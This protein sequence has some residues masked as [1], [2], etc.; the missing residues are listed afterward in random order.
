MIL[1]SLRL[2]GGS[3]RR[4]R[5]AGTALGLLLAL[6]LHAPRKAD[7]E[8]LSNLFAG[9]SLSAGSLTFDSWTLITNDATLDVLD[10]T[11]IDVTASV[12]GS[13]VTLSY[14]TIGMPGPGTW[15]VDFDNL[16]MTTVFSYVVNHTGMD[17]YITDA[18]LSIAGGFDFGDDN[19]DGLV[20]ATEFFPATV[21]L[22]EAFVDTL[23]GTEMQTDTRFLGSF[24]TLTVETTVDLVYDDMMGNDPISL[25]DFTQT[26]AVP[27]PAS[28]GMGAIA[29]MTF[30]WVRRRERRTSRKA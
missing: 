2:T 30:G 19:V 22:L 17:P 8:L 5:R 24:S 13:I 3:V 20:R 7:A 11:L 10:P 1:R 12:T 25:T 18:G 6:M 21:D 4:P 28:M 26:F 9:G 14:A 16:M 23:E 29:L 27:E 15:F